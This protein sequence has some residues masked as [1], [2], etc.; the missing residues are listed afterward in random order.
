MLMLDQR[1][2]ICMLIGM[3]I[4]CSIISSLNSMA[5]SMTSGINKNED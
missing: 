2:M 4:C 3:F 1:C 5:M